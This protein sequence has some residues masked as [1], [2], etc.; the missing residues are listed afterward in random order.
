M[1]R[2]MAALVLIFSFSVAQV[3]A[4]DTYDR[5]QELKYEIL[6]IS[7]NAQGEYD[8]DDNNL[9]VR[10]RLDPLVEEL[11]SLAPPRSEQQKLVD[12]IG[13]WY[14]VWADG[15]GGPPGQGARGDSIWQVVFPEGYYWNVARNQYGPVQN[16][17]YLRGKFS[18][19]TDSLAIEFTK[20]VFNPQWSFAEPTRLA[21][22]AEFGAFDAN[23]TPFPPGTSPIGKKGYLANVYVD[24]DIRICRGGGT[25][26]GDN[27]YL[28]I[29]ERD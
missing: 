6:E 11:I 28:Y 21:M 18:V 15:P 25:D 27:T 24:E 16:M 13:T 14:Q 22:L 4:D 2:L 17:G 8:S 3:Q 20:A 9:E 5:I 12:V 26:F 1:T 10:Q 29:L 23:P 19:N 7:F